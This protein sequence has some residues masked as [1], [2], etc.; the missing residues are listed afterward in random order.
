MQQHKKGTIFMSFKITVLPGDGI[1]PE[2]C[3][4]AVNILR[5]VN[6]FQHREFQIEEKLI[7]GAAIHATGTALPESTLQACL[8]SDA[9]LLGA[10][11]AP[12]FDHLSREEKP[13]AALL[14][15]RTELGGFANLRP[16]VAFKAVTDC[17][18]LQN[19][20]VEGADV[21]I[22]RELLGGLYFSEPRGF[23]MGGRYAMNTMRYSIEEIERV[24]H[25]G[26]EQARR[27]R[28][29]LTSVDKANVLETSQLWRRTV[30][31]VSRSYPDVKLDH[32]YVDACAMHLISNPTRFD[33][34][35]TE[36]LFG[37]ILSDAAAAITGSLGMLAS[38]TIG[39]GINLYEP[40][41]GS[42]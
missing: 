2:V 17:S 33:V 9:V 37:D 32:M 26:F 8:E 35:L 4:E 1:G 12:E 3:R 20:R 13:E 21:L 11:G 24:A 39:G 36:N 31:E 7:G 28:K 25:V 18:P 15:L 5:A 23:D 38:A 22:V 40:V 30:N 29:K 14:R 34:M 19:S 6:G 42:A 10:V 41:H 27:R 16:A